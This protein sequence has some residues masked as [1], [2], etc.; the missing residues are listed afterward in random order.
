MQMMKV[1]PIVGLALMVALSMPAQAGEP[2]AGQPVFRYLAG[3]VAAEQF[4]VAARMRQRLA[5]DARFIAKVAAFHSTNSIRFAG[6][7][8]GRQRQ[9]IEDYLVAVRDLPWTVAADGA[10][11][12]EHWIRRECAAIFE[13]ETTAGFLNKVAQGQGLTVSALMRSDVLLYRAIR[14]QVTPARSPSD[15]RIE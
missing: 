15:I 3:P 13:L 2:T 10:M 9:M 14:A 5:S 4:E 12:S 8:T 6:M 7:E 1:W 11:T